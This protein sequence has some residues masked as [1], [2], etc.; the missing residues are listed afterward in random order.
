MLPQCTIRLN[1]MVAYTYAPGIQLNK[2]ELKT[3]YKCDFLVHKSY[4]TYIYLL[5]IKLQLQLI[6]KCALTV[7]TQFV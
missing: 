5:H 7:H 1:K 2:T 6:I 4:Y 3:Q